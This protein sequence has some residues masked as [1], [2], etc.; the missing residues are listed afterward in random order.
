PIGAGACRQRK[1]HGLATWQHLGTMR[2]LVALYADDPFRLAA[3]RR[4]SHDAVTTLAKDDRVRVPAHT[5]KTVGRTD[6]H[7]R[8]TADGN[9][10][11]CRIDARTKGDRSPIRRE[12]GV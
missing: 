1:Q 2:Q 5:K 8:S 9:L 7:G 6:R 4:D 3:V 12:D 10:L 11:E